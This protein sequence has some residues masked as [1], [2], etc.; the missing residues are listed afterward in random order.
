MTHEVL[1]PRL[2]DNVEEGVLVTWFVERGMPVKKGD[3]LAEVQVEK[4]STEVSSDV[5]GHILE[6]R[7]GPGDVIAQ[8]AVMALIGDE[9]A[10]A[11]PVSISVEGTSTRETTVIAAAAVSPAARRLARELGVDLATVTGTGPDGRITERDI[12][13]AAQASASTPSALRPRTVNR[14][15]IADRLRGWLLE[16]AQVTVTATADVT[17]LNAALAKGDEKI[18]TK[19][20]LLAA[21]VRASGL[22]LRKHTLLSARWTDEG[23]I[24]PSSIDIGVAVALE[25]G[26]IVPVLREADAKTLPQLSSEIAQMADRARRNKLKPGEVEGGIFS[27]SNLGAFGIEAFTPLLNPPQTAI[28]GMG[29]AKQVPAVVDSK[30]AIRT[31][32]TLSLTFDHR[33]VDGAPASAFLKD[34]VGSLEM[35]A[36][37][38]GLA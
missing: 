21:V 19:G 12:R 33:V 30:L 10:E 20:S 16:T 5:S 7:A 24:V 15:I 29:C 35:P 26:L 38:L 3:L 4:T 8:G 17:D 36:V 22:A 11:T 31:Q 6:L 14:R 18:Q 25:D 37:V 28:L 23:L 13:G 34:V 27:I 9:S 1:M 32:M 2:S